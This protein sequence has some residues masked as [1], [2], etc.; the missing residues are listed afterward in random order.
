MRVLTQFALNII[1][2][3]LTSFYTKLRMV[4]SPVKLLTS[5]KT[6]SFPLRK[7]F[8][9]PVRVPLSARNDELKGNVF[10]AGRFTEGMW[11]SNIGG[12]HIS[13]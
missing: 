4:I 13:P 10:A 7:L 9:N 1:C 5:L 12:K 3:I 6:T 2:R 11:D 8:V